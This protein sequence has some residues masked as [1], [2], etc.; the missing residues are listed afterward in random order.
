MVSS[1]F[2]LD[3]LLADCIDISVFFFSGGLID[4]GREQPMSL[5]KAKRDQIRT[6]KFPLDKYLKRTIGYKTL[7]LPQVLLLLLKV[8]VLLEA[9]TTSVFLSV[10]LS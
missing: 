3:Y 9:L 4:D 1:L 2:V 10:Y 5:A 6:A 7:R 8:L